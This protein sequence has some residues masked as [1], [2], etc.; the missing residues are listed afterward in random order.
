MIFSS[1]ILDIVMPLNESRKSWQLP[2][3]IEFFIDRE[4]YFELLTSYLFVTVFIGTTT[5][6]TVQSF[7]LMYVQHTCAMF[8]IT[9]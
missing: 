1:N 3:T 9:R 4:K 5:M 7:L 6:I 2:V 8:Q